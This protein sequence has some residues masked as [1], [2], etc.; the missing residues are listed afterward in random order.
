MKKRIVEKAQENV[1]YFPEEPWEKEAIKEFH[2]ANG[3]WLP[4][5]YVYEAAYNLQPIIEEVAK[6]SCSQDDVLYTIDTYGI[7]TKYT[8]H[9]RFITDV[10]DSY[11]RIQEAAKEVRTDSDTWLPDAITLAI[12][13]F[14]YELFEVL[15]KHYKAETEIDDTRS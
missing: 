2:F 6:G 10:P 4:V 11:W 7:G 15:F 13:Q 5:D 14:H 12:Q 3:G 9:N 8:E 1:L